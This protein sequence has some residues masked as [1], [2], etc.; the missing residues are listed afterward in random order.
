MIKPHPCMGVCVGVRVSVCMYMCV[1][2]NM[3]HRLGYSDVLYIIIYIC[4]VITGLS[5]NG[6]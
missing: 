1:G 3:V 4:I 2:I 6:P 5:Q